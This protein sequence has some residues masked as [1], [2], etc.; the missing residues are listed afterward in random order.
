MLLLENDIM[1]K[2]FDDDSHYLTNHL[3]G[4]KPDA[5]VLTDK[6]ILQHF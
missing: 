5:Y 1:K 3:S 2:N 4:L 6:C